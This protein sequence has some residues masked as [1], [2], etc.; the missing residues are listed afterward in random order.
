MH[1]GCVARANYI[2]ELTGSHE[3]DCPPTVSDQVAGVTTMPL[4]LAFRARHR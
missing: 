4:R 1:R 2:R 3:A